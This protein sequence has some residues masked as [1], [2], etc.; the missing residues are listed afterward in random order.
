MKRS[1]DCHSHPHYYCLAM[2][3]IHTTL[4][5]TLMSGPLSVSE[6]IGECGKYKQLSTIELKPTFP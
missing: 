1:Q 2:T 4:S 6:I 3:E 5:P